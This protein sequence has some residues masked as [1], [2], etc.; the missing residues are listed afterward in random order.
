[1][2]IGLQTW[3]TEGD[4]RPF[5]AL[6]GGLSAR[7]H[8]VTLAVTNTQTNDYTRYAR[9]LQFRIVHAHNTYARWG[10][11]RLARL[12][13]EIVTSKPIEQVKRLFDDLFEPAVDEMYDASTRLCEEND[14]VVGHFLVHPL[15][16]AAAK[17][18]RPYAS[19]VYSPDFLPSRFRGP[20]LFP[21][22][23]T[24]MNP[25][26]WK[27]ARTMT[28]K[29]VL[30]YIN[31]LRGREGYPAA[32]DALSDVWDSGP[33]ML[34]AASPTLLE[35]PADWGD[36]VDV[37]GYLPLPDEAEEWVMPDDLRRFLDAGAPPV[38]MT[39]GSMP[40]S[41]R[42]TQS[43]I[44]AARLGGFRAIVQSRIVKVTNDP[45]IHHLESAPHGRIFPHCSA[46]VHHGGAGTS[47]AASLAG[48]PSVIV[49]HFG[50]Q[51]FWGKQLQRAGL[52]HRILHE[53]S[54]TPKTLAAEIRTVL[55]SPAIQERAR[56]VAA[57]MQAEHGVQRAS[58]RIEERLAPR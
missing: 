37:C 57:S 5:I 10:A 34:I 2:K 15:Q 32:N 25:W 29:M 16:L 47:H 7:G 23:G 50:D 1:M 30:Q 8:D 9:S 6:A 18:G 51:I 13:H 12:E 36:R 53:R 49:E 20:S 14:A 17:R 35:R 21:D 19:L 40:H 39:F 27:L 3:G 4:I 44:D 22:L 28:N 26:W 33:L 54:V 38:Y 56:R 55:S 24:W 11:D 42:A 41:Q 46:V 43:F 31:A 48:C 58:E 45:N 52:T